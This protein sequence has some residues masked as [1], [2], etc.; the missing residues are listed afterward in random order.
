MNP[1]E[2]HIKNLITDDGGNSLAEFCMMKNYP[3]GFTF[4]PHKHEHVEINFVKK[5]RCFMKFNDDVVCFEKNDVMII[6]PNHE[7]YFYVTEK[8]S[9]LVQLEFKMD[10]FP[11]LKLKPDLEDHL[12]FLHN[13]L[14]NSQKY[15]KVIYNPEIT[16]LIEKIVMEI[17]EER[18]NYKTLAR[19]MYS[20]LFI[21][22]SRHIKDTLKYT[23]AL[24]NDYLNKALKII[25]VKYNE[26]LDLEQLALNC[27]VSSRYLRNLFKRYLNSTPVE[28]ILSLKITKSKEFMR[29]P[30]LNLKEIAYRTG[31]TNQPY[32]CKKFRDHTG[33]T[34]FEFRKTLFRQS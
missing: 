18:E 3:A 28:Y 11:E 31:F 9:T 33:M 24:P 10:I 32:F 12:I 7:H 4:G 13:I 22:I 34:P 5:G 15:M 29:N 17:Q 6:F 23:Q 27:Y 16:E 30:D 21:V 25:N 20:E 1:I 8:P 26:E 2:N 19:L 14:T